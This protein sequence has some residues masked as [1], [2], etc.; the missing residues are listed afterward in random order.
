MII[1][2]NLS[3]IEVLYSLTGANKRLNE[4]VHDA[5]FTNHLSLLKIVASHLISLLPTS[6]NFIYPLP[7]SMLDRFL[8]I[9]PEISGKIRWLNLESFS[10]ERI[11]LAT[12]YPNLFGLGLY[13]IPRE[14]AIHLLSGNLF[15]YNSSIDK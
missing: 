13:N 4:I 10:M 9:L 8:E 1:L 7:D 14:R 3:N 12:R 2:K 6:Q 5:I 15:D 11:L